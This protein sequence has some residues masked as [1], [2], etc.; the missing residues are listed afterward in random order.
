MRNKTIRQINQI[1]LV[2]LNC[3]NCK[4]DFYSNGRL[5]E[6]CQDIID[7]DQNEVLIRSVFQIQIFRFLTFQS[8]LAKFALISPQFKTKLCPL[9]FNN[10]NLTSFDIIGLVDTF[11]KKNIL[12]FENRK[13][14]GLNSAISNLRLKTENIKVDS[15][16]L[17]PYVFE[18]LISI[19]LFG[20]VNMIDVNS[21]NQIKNLRFLTFDKGYFVDMIRKNGIKWI[22]SLNAHLNINLSLSNLQ[23]I[24]KVYEKNRI[25]LNVK[26]DI[27]MTENRFSKLFRDED[28]CLYKDF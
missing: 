23:E 12:A 25:E 5:L 22:R 10:T 9:V 27:Y 8:S 26:S 20:P 17:N 24:D 28:L 7:S 1:E 18:K 13:F 15:N 6:T 11:Y 4:M 16:L 19:Q 2:E 21:F 14:Y 3:L